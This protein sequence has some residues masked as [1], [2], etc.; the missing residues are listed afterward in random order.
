[1]L[2]AYALHGLVGHVS[3]YPLSLYVVVDHARALKKR[4][5]LDRRLTSLQKL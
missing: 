4:A 3:L 2:F 5:H 1:M